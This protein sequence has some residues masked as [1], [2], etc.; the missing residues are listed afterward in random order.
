MSLIIPLWID[1]LKNIQKF[2]GP[3]KGRML[4]QEVMNEQTEG[5]AYAG[6]LGRGPSGQAQPGGL[7][8]RGEWLL[9]EPKNIHLAGTDRVAEIDCRCALN[10]RHPILCSRE[11]GRRKDFR[12][13]EGSSGWT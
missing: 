11:V 8:H 1:L 13:V 10:E 9:R 6:F 2:P 5:V 3:N 4:K 7:E 12:F